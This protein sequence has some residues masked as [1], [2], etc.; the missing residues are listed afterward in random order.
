MITLTLCRKQG[1]YTYAKPTT[2]FKTGLLA[3]TVNHVI[4]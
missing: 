3:T 1:L 4:L 2:Y